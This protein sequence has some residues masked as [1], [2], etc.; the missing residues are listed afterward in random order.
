MT[1]DF[2]SIDYFTDP[3]LV[4]DPHPYFD[5]MRS[6][7]PIA[8]EPHHGVIAVTGWEEANDVYRDSE[9][10]SS[11]IA[12]M[13][14]FT[15]LPFQPEGDDITEQI[16]RHRTQIPMYE[17]MVTMDPPEHTNAR[18]ILARLLTPKRL[19]ENEDFMWRLADRHIDEFIADGKCEFLAAYAK[20]FSLLVV[21]DLLGVPEEDHDAFREAFGAERPGT[22]IGSL[23]HETI[24][25]NP[26]EWADDKFTQYI[27]D[28]RREPR[29][30]VLTAIATAKYP[31]G[32][33]PEVIDVVRTAT[34][35]FAAGQ[36]TTAKLL[37]AALQ[38]LGDR[39]DIQQ[40][41]RE[42][43]SRIPVFIEECLR[44]ESPVKTVFRMVRKSTTVGDLD[45][46][47]GTTVMVAPGAANRDPRRFENP[48]EFDIDRKNVREHLAFSRGIHSCPGAPLARVEGRVSI[49]RLLDRL[50][51]IEIDA[52]KHGGP[53]ERNYTYEP[54]FI[55]R[56]LTELNITFKPIG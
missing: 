49:E 38:I 28:R 6:K 14:P 26:L 7:C 5:H 16:A 33:T 54:T 36:E 24:A 9:N 47:A 44:M 23:D 17:H 8:R 15:P 42:D 53:G 30:D 3:S 4:P 13:G 18:S 27:E 41:L 29:D 2:D 45:A 21:A 46:P 12:V 39:P 35:L 43:R 1:T 55:L 11:C 34:F 51:D 32:S 22:R 25:T 40:T 50:A 19:K 10:L 56:G 20:P 52:D 48:H 31:D 37:G